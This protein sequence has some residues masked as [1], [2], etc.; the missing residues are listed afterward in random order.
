VAA[1]RLAAAVVTLCALSCAHRRDMSERARQD[2]DLV[3]AVRPFR[4]WIDGLP[5]CAPDVATIGFDELAAM[6]LDDPVAVRG[7]LN[8]QTSPECTA[9]F[10]GSDEC[11]NTC[12]PKWVVLSRDG[13]S[14]AERELEIQRPDD[15]NPMGGMAR[16]CDLSRLRAMI[17]DPEVIVSGTLLRGR[18]QI[19]GVFDASLCVVRGKP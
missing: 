3:A 8:L 6:K 11:C 2:R 15:R 18:S 9:M 19:V 7:R 16:D 5:R 10:C 12:F 4:A 17:G 14:G 13:A 1:R